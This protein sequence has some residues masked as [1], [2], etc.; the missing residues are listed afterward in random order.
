MALGA[1]GQCVVINE[2]MINGPGSCDGA[3]SP[4]TEEWFEL[5]NTCN[6]PVDIGCFIIADGDFTIRI[7]Q[8]TM[9]SANGFYTI[10]SNNAGFT[11]DLN[12]SNCACAIGTGIGVLTNNGEQ[13]ILA[14]G[15]G[16]VQD[17]IVWG[18][19]QFPMFVNAPSSSGCQPVNLSFQNAGG[20]F[21]EPIPSGGANGCTLARACDGSSQWVQRCT[22]T[23]TPGESNGQPTLPQITSEEAIICP[24]SCVSFTAD[25]TGP[26]L[27]WS[28]SF[29]GSSASGSTVQN[30]SGIC[31]DSQG[32][33]DVQLTINTLC[34]NFSVTA[35]EWVI[36]EPAP[37]I[38]ISPAGNLSICQGQSVQLTATG[39]GQIQWFLNGSPIGSG[40]QWNATQAGT[41]TAS[42]S[43]GSCSILSAPVIVSEVS[44]QTPVIS[45]GGS[46]TLC[47]GGSVVLSIPPISGSIQ[48]YLNGTAISGATSSSYSASQTGSYTVTVSST[49]CS[50]TSAAVQVVV[51][52][53]PSAAISPGGP[54]AICPGQ[55]ITLSAAAGYTFY[56]WFFGGSAVQ[57]ANSNTFVA[58]APGNYSLQ[59]LNNGCAASSGILAIS[60]GS[61]NTPALLA[62]NTTICPGETTTLSATPGFANYEWSHN[63][64]PD[65]TLV[66]ATVE[67]TEPGS[68]AVTVT[69]GQC[70]AQS[71]SLNISL[72]DLP[73]PS[74]NASGPLS[75]CEGEEVV[76]SV[77]M[78]YPECLWHLNGIP[79][80]GETSPTISVSQT[81]SYSVVVSD[82]ICSVESVATLVSVFDNPALNLLPAGDQ[83]ICEGQSAQYSVN[84]PGTI[85]WSVNGTS[86]GSGTSIQLNSPGIVTVSLTDVNGC[87]AAAGPYEVTVIS[88][89]ELE[90]LTPEGT[91]TCS[92]ESIQIGASGQWA[93]YSWTQNGAMIS[94]APTISVLQ[95][96]TYVL[97]TLTPDGCVA[98][99]NIQISVLAAPQVEI[100]GES[101]L[102]LCEGDQI[103]LTLSGGQVG[104]WYQGNNPITEFASSFV[105][106]DQPGSYSALVTGSNGCS[107]QTQSVQVT[108]AGPFSPSILI[109]PSQP[110]EGEV[111]VLSLPFGTTTALW[112][113]GHSGLSLQ[114]T[115]SGTYAVIATSQH[116]CVGEAETNV[117]FTPMPIAEAGANQLIYCGDQVQIG[118]LA[119]GGA[120]FW[121]PE[122]GLNDPTSEHPFASPERTT[123]Y[124]LIVS[125]GRCT[126]TDLV[127]VSVDCGQIYVPTAFTP[128]Q[129]GINDAW[130]PVASGLAEYDLLIMDRW[131]NRVFETNDPSEWWTGNV[132]G[133][134]HFAETGAYVWRLV[135]RFEGRT[136]EEVLTGHVLLVR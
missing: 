134:N 126:S 83:Q 102:V 119:T 47:Q 23:I 17:G 120:I 74:I 129:D 75:F 33:F 1:I 106:V 69:Q 133:G 58:S 109:S 89:P 39:A 91:V 88:V 77:N 56:Q 30:P 43:V 105:V 68:Y 19:G 57:G 130:R 38:G 122:T 34:G 15:A 45:A 85:S 18:G 104:Q 66:G 51:N 62:S 92:G 71:P 86:A 131:G 67:V 49:G 110:C 10:G 128:D 35:E 4:H 132:K 125:N 32:S 2:V 42:A 13:V 9:I 11:V 116:G 48:W 72:S 27:S 113:N 79:M 121:Q 135:I 123:T 8:G 52:P 25:A 24:G 5:Y 115:E 76:L 29:P 53:L 96:G 103:Q 36:V 41:Y 14:N 136:D 3:C 64:E 26:V 82:G 127:T 90:I 73:P 20:G 100:I 118:A 6:Y 50:N 101:Q 12:I 60:P 46:L 21:F 37:T 22:S 114:T 16:V 70:T 95:G 28:W 93:S 108:G 87:M 117:V 61:I 44:V 55:I 7:P 98:Q 65:P 124:Q 63:E 84:A 81:G 78:S 97:N 31:Y 80:P 94:T 54:L 40:D 107:A 59:V 99:A 111:V 112:S